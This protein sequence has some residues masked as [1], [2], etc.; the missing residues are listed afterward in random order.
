MHQPA[1]IAAVDE[2]V[3]QAWRITIQVNALEFDNP[4]L[5][6]LRLYPIHQL[7]FMSQETDSLRVKAELQCQRRFAGLGS[8]FC[9]PDFSEAA[10]PKQ[11]GQHQTT[12]Y[13]V[14]RPESRW[15]L[16]Q[17]TDELL[18]FLDREVPGQA[19]A[20]RIGRSSQGRA[21]R[22]RHLFQVGGKICLDIRLSQLSGYFRRR[23]RS[24]FDQGLSDLVLDLILGSLGCCLDLTEILLALTALSEAIAAHQLQ[25]RRDV[26]RKGLARSDTSDLGRQP[27]HRYSGV[28]G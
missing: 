15:S 12:C 14:S 25:Y 4:G 2:L 6:T 23:R 27:P 22:A 5:A 21:D 8:M 24:D 3:G 18:R 20:C 11:V 10:D 13:P 16:G 26:L 7:G 28:E 19:P 1:Q 17:D 9:L